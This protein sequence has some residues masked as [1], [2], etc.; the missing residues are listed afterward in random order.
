M[1][2][3]RFKESDIQEVS[4]LAMTTFLKFNGKDYFSESAIQKVLD[5]WDYQKNNH[6]VE[7]MRRTDIYFCAIDSQENIIGLI[8]GTKDKV[9]SL[10]VHGD[11]HHQG[12]GRMLMNM[13]EFEARNQGSRQI[14]LESS[15][16][17]APFYE[18]MDFQRTSDLINFEGLKVYSMRKDLKIEER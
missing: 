2:I 9:K 13:F 14:T 17:A 4:T 10:F 8:R 5:S 3:R 1:T 12:I 7:D 11:F 15:L 18:R 16:F 6:F